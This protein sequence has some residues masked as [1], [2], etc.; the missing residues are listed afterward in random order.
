[1]VL[2]SYI[3]TIR[4]NNFELLLFVYMYIFAIFEIEKLK[5]EKFICF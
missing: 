5:E 2:K 3:L 1:M 4:Q